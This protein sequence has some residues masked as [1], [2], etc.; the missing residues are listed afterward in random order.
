MWRVPVLAKERNLFGAD[1]AKSKR[2][3]GLCRPLPTFYMSDYSVLGL[4][5]DRPEE[6]VRVLGEHKYRLTENDCGAEAAIDH[7][8]RLQEMVRL[9]STQGLRC[10]I[11]DVVSEV[12]QG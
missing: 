5:V 6:A 11:A 12:Y 1:Q 10:E 9:L 4:L 3:Q 7:P 8:K 2:F